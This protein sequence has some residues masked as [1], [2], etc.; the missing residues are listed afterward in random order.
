MRG[1]TWGCAGLT[2]LLYGGLSYFSFGP[3]RR[4]ANGLLGF[5]LQT[6]GFEAI[7]GLDYLTVLSPVGRALY[8]STVWPLDTAFIVALTC[9]FALV[10]RKMPHR[11]AIIVA[12]LA[13]AAF[14]LTE[15]ATVASVMRVPVEV[16]TPD[17]ITLIGTFTT[18][19]FLTL[20][21][22]V[23]LLLAALMRRRFN[24]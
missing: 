14:D 20:T 5:D 1:L 10:T 7:A 9:L 22:A 2:A 8:L 15:N 4:E 21:L 3:L 13:F 23:V 6:F 24:A 17:V 11:L 12:T 19:K 18:L 16:V